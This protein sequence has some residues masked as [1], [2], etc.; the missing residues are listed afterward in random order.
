MLI[1]II[2]I[3]LT[4]RIAEPHGRYRIKI[5]ESHRWLYALI[6]MGLVAAF[7]Y[8]IGTDYF[9]YE[10]YFN[11]TLHG[12]GWN[13]EWL[14]RICSTIIMKVFGDT[15]VVFALYSIVIL[16]LVGYTLFQNSENYRESLFLFI[17]L[18]YFFC[19]LN[20]L[21]QYLAIS[22]V[23]FATR[24]IFK[25]NY[26]VFYLLVFFAA[27][28]HRS[29]IIAVIL[30]LLAI[31][32]F[33]K[34]IYI[35]ISLGFLVMP[36]FRNNIITAL[37][38][39]VPAYRGYLLRNTQVMHIGEIICYVLLFSSFLVLGIQHIDSQKNNRKFAFLFNC[40]FI[41]FL[42]YMVGFFIPN[43][44]RISLYFEIY[45]VMYI[46]LILALDN[47]DV[48][49]RNRLIINVLMFSFFIFIIGYI[50]RYGVMPYRSFLMLFEP[51]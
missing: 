51:F 15:K 24:Y 28:I 31:K 19:S 36:V 33:P 43:I 39:V 44:N 20:I 17:T 45:F 22:V 8:G 25:K 9:N 32:P 18:G 40:L 30:P 16:L 46:P 21:R 6:P 7:R 49:S 38:S 23:F 12:S 50:K 34:S 4:I 37:S 3:A 42:F 14:F 47:D 11:S 1:Y 48:R 2:M 41:S 27:G 35:V 26:F 13:M 29:A 10:Q 5:N